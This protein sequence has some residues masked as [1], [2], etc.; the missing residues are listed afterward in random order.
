MKKDSTKPAKVKPV[1][2]PAK[3]FKAF[4][5][6]IPKAGKIPKGNFKINK[7]SQRGK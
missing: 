1:G 5:Q 6:K 3:N 2:T 4:N 7:G